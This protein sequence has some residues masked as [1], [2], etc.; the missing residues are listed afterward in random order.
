MARRDGSENSPAGVRG[1][2]AL[3]RGLAVLV[4]IGVALSQNRRAIRP[5]VVLAALA[6]V[7]YGRA[8]RHERR[9]GA[10]VITHASVDT[11]WSFWLR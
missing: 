2:R 11:I 6:G 5:R 4:A 8:W 1:V 10:S 3:E 9:V 7:F